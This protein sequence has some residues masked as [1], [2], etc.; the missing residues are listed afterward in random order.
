MRLARAKGALQDALAGDVTVRTSQTDRQP[1]FVGDRERAR[2]DVTNAAVRVNNA[3]LELENLPA[4]D[5]AR[6]FSFDPCDI[7]RMD[8]FALRRCDIAY[9]TGHEA[10]DPGAARVDIACA[11]GQIPRPRAQLGD[12]ERE[13][14]PLFALPQLF[15][16]RFD[17][18]ISVRLGLRCPVAAAASVQCHVP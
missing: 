14:T 13:L 3:V 1:G 8:G 2:V 5:A 12:V 9:R 18:A 4:L 11:G 17:A 10:D 16:Q 6:N 7:V 15:A